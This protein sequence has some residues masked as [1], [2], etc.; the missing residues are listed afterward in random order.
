M[1]H[2]CEI[3]PAGG[4]GGNAGAVVRVQAG[5]SPGPILLK[6]PAIDRTTGQGHLHEMRRW[7][8]PLTVLIV[9][10][11]VMTALGWGA[12]AAAPSV[13]DWLAARIGDAGVWA[14]LGLVVIVGAIATYRSSKFG[15]GR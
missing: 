1:P 7:A 5:A 11:V 6:A 13:G 4:R 9:F 14:V 15:E 10:A 2:G 8:E 3:W 12:H